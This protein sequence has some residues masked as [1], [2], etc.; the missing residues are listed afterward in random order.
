MGSYCSLILSLLVFVFVFGCR[1]V[2]ITPGFDDNYVITWGDNNVLHLDQG[3][4]IQ[5][6]MDK[7]SG[8][9]FASK[10]SYGSGYFH[11]NMKLPAKDS[12][13]VVTAFYLTSHDGD[14]HDELDFEFLGNR[15]GKPYILQTNV[16]ANGEGNREQRILLWFDPTAGYHTYKILWNPHQIV[17]YVDQIPIRVFKNNRKIGVDYPSKPMQIE[18]SLWDGESW[19][20]D[21]GK[22]KINWSMAPFKAYFRGFNIDGCS[23]SSPPSSSSS[24]KSSSSSSSS[25]SNTDDQ[26]VCY[27]TKLWWNREKYWKLTPYEQKAYENVK[28]YY[29][30][31]DYCSDKPRFPKPPP[32]CPQ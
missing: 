19:A 16:F 2:A 12:A 30:T 6:S 11:L 14:A 25:S 18:A 7:S 8:S 15:E 26:S 9:G 17:F 20:T 13:G 31:Y 5:L 23:S 28:N 3:R 21:G 24:Y 29:M 10:L 22:E 4:T 32:E 1:V 27:S